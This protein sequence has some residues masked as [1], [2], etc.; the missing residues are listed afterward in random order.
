MKKT[1]EQR[2]YEE[3]DRPGFESWVTTLRDEEGGILAIEVYSKDESHHF[4]ELSEA[5]Q[6]KVMAWIKANVLPK[7]TPLNG[8]TSYGM[9][10]VLQ[11]R[12]NIYVTNNQFKEAML[13]CD[14]YPV[15]IDELNWRYSIS[16]AS[17]IFQIQEDGRCGLMIPDCVMDYPHAEWVY[18][19]GAWECS[20]C[21]ETGGEQECW[22]TP[23]YRPQLRQC[24]ICGAIMGDKDAPFPVRKV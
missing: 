7:E 4:D 15:C 3:A 21:G 13:L 9:K 24:P 18:R 12:T 2:F 1:N 16:K 19:H 6:E 20:N 14:F 8:H 5:E 10:H 17:P 11:H 23:G 22:Y